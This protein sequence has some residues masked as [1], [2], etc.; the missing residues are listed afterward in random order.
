MKKKLILITAAIVLLLSSACGGGSQSEPKNTPE[1]TP[2]NT[3]SPT[4]E[5]VS[6]TSAPEHTVYVGKSDIRYTFYNPTDDAVKSGEKPTFTYFHSV[7][8]IP[9]DNYT[10]LMVD[11]VLVPG[12]EILSA[13]SV[14]EDGDL[15]IKLRSVT[16]AIGADIGWI[17]E[18]GTVMV[19]YKDNS[20]ECKIDDTAAVVNGKNVALTTAHKLVGDII[21]VSPDFLRVTMGLKVDYYDKSRFPEY[22]GPP[23]SYSLPFPFPIVTVDCITDAESD[24]AEY[25]LEE[26][27]QRLS[28]GYDSFYATVTKSDW[29]DEEIYEDSFKALKAHIDGTSYVGEV[30]SFW[31][32]CGPY[33]I[34]Y[35]KYTRD[36]YF[37]KT[38]ISQISVDMFNDTNDPELFM[39]GYF[40]N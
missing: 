35:D 1:G 24:T 29:Y 5:T 27:K 15:F 30:G 26:T 19:S 21:Y 33:V 37:Y 31:V 8:E 36:K 6:E 18:D 11:R 28:E 23:V 12:A 32:F 10:L 17:I 40:A 7:E 16:E 22:D 34:L 4:T 38:D 13:Q 20:A 3:S 9:G 2:N 14:S 25:A 39:S